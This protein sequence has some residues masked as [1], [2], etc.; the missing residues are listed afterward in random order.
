MTIYIKNTIHDIK[1]SIFVSV[2]MSAYVNN[3]FFF[4]IKNNADF[5]LIVIVFRSQI[6]YEL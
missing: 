6:R 4:K 1:E 3:V 2:Y 5:V